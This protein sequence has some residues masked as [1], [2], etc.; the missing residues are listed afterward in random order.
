L[1]GNIT[2]TMYSIDGDTLADGHYFFRVVASDRP[3][4]SAETAREA[5]LV[6][7]QVTIDSTPPVVTLSGAA[8]T[9][10]GFQIYADAVDRGSALR[11]CEYSVDA[12]TWTPVEAEDGVTDSAQERFVI[13]SANLPAGEH[14]ISVRVYDA[15]GNAGVAKAVIQ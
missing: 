14:V 9:G 6:S 7:V 4:N 1:R 8:R 2:E 10:G 3:S 11:R 13:R 12:G 5:E 15:A